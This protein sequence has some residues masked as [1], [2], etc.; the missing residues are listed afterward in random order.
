LEK[1]VFIKGSNA[2]TAI[3]RTA[4]DQLLFA[5]VG[6]ATFFT[7]MAIMEGENPKKR[8]QEK[9]AGTLWSN[10]AIWPAVQVVNFT[11]VPLNLRLVVV[12]FVSI[13]E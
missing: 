1:N 7:C 2:A 4:C 13:G 3:A 5:P 8:V 6:I 9:W 10:W 11:F 12:N